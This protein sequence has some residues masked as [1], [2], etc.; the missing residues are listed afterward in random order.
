MK[1]AQI[2]RIFAS[3][4]I[5]TIMKIIMYL[6]LKRIKRLK[7]ELNT[8]FISFLRPTRKVWVDFIIDIPDEFRKRNDTFAFAHLVEHMI[9]ESILRHNREIKV[10]GSVRAD[11]IRIE[12]NAPKEKFEKEF[13]IVA[14]EIFCIDINDAMFAHERDVICSE[15]RRDAADMT[16]RVGDIVRSKGFMNT[17]CYSSSAADDERILRNASIDDVRQFYSQLS[18]YFVET[19][20]IVVSAFDPFHRV[21]RIVPRVVQ[22]IPVLNTSRKTL[23]WTPE[24]AGAGIHWVNDQTE[25]DYSEIVVSFWDSLFGEGVSQH[26]F[27]ARLA[28]DEFQKTSGALFEDSRKLGVYD[29][30]K[31]WYAYRDCGFV[32]YRAK[33]KNEKISQYVEMFL[34]HIEGMRGKPINEDVLAQKKKERLANL[35][36]AVF[37]NGIL[38]DY[39]F[40]NLIDY[41]REVS[42]AQLGKETKEVDVQMVRAVVEKLFDVKHMQI[43]VIGAD[44]SVC[45]PLRTHLV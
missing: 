42:L 25:S 19:A 45:I 12:F 16:W 43:I 24:Y 10:S 1:C 39:L 9:V 3:S 2:A 44:E 30:S 5:L 6:G 40:D 29:V 34:T 27:A 32:T 7:T 36:R 28:M 23:T 17:I 35:R 41:G 15:L 20:T 31:G 18:A 14:K 22:S 11:R 8:Y 4:H 38:Y 21:C 13:A 26:V 37:Q 33:V